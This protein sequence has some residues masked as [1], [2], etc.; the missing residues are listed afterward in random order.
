MKDFKGKV[1]VISGGAGGIGF[2]LAKHC[3]AQG[4]KVVLA[5]I[6]GPALTEAVRILRSEGA[7]VLGLHTDVSKL[8]D[9]EKLAAKTLETYGGVHLLFN[10]AGVQTGK[11]EPFWES[12]IADWQWVLGVNLWGVVHGIKVFLPIMLQQKTPC[13]VVNTASVAG[14]MSSSVLGIYSVSKAAVIM[15]SETLYLQLKEN[16]SSIGV[17]VACPSV[18]RSRLNDA[19]RNRPLELA[20]PPSGPL[21]QRQQA[22]INLFQQLNEKGMPPEHF[23]GLVFE[24]IQNDKL[25]LLSH[26]DYNPAIRQRA[27]NLLQGLNPSPFKL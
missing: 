27:E 4:M 15:L 12:T 2:G 22:I 23:A 19:E 20:N 21:T 3:A 9:I 25:Y 7:E 1:A 5:D 11:G 18:V 16:N 6:E 10:N 17:T 8:A 14:L 26:P 24:A 13:H